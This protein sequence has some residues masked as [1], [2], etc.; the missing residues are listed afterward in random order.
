MAW[1]DFLKNKK[2]EQTA[3]EKEEKAKT[4]ENAGLA[5]AA[6]EVVDRYGSANKEFLVGHG[7]VDNETGQVLSRSLKSVSESKVNPDHRDNNIHQ[8]AGF[9]AEIES[10][11]RKNAEHIISKRNVRN[12]RT[13]DIEKQSYG[14]NEIGGKNDQLYDHVELDANGR[15]IQGTATQLK[16]VGKGGNDTLNKLVS[17]DYDKYFENDAPIEVPSDYYDGVREAAGEQAEGL[18]KQIDRLK[19]NP[20]KNRDIIDT[21]EKQL[22]KLESIRDG[23]SIRKGNVSSKE[24]EFARLHPKLATARDI[25]GVSHRAGLEQAKYGAA[26]GGGMSLV[27]NLVAVAKGEKEPDEAALSVVKDTGTGAA[28][29]YT[30]AFA[31]SAIKGAMQNAKD[32]AVRSLSK[33]NLP[34]AIVTATLESGKTLSKYFKGEIDGVECLTELGEKGTGMLSS[35]MFAMLGQIAIPIPVVGGMI[36]SMLGYALSSACYGQL[37]AALQEAKL[38]REERIRIEAECAEAVAMLRQYRAEVERYVSEY[39]ID[40]INTFHDAFDGIKGALQI[41]DVDGFIAGSNT[42]TRKLGGKPQ[43]ETFNEFDSLMKSDAAF[44]L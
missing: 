16:F 30:T 26:I 13:D 39:L 43:F 8:Q 10:N 23:K 37:V 4:L 27:R 40:H 25:F 18:R 28:V 11:S 41:G 12:T 9:S 14:A 3:Q 2:I 24:A 19:E 17:K 38:A 35:A 20:N 36:G 21:K 34:A 5:G 32:A 1:Y 44:K 33:T 22:K 15:P 6:A 7:G 31:G 42:I 29:S